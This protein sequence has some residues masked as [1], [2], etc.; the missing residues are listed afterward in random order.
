MAY[1]VNPTENAL[2]GRVKQALRKEEDTIS[3]EQTFLVQRLNMPSEQGKRNPYD[4]PFGA[5]HRYGGIGE[6]AY[7]SLTGIFSF[8][9]MG[10]GAFEYGAVQRSFFEI[11]EYAKAGKLATGTVKLKKG[12]IHYLCNKGMENGVRDVIK[13]LARSEWGRIKTSEFVGL[14][15]TLEKTER[16]KYDAVGWLELDN[17]FMFFVDREMF[18]KTAALFR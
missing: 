11:H 13:A 9:Y 6:D 12:D 2:K 7:K 4:K 1:K 10:N 8:A 15:S 5:G 3:M 16:T 14:K 17:H 18:E